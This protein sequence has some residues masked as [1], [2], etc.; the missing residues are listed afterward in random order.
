MA[1]KEI[2]KDKPSVKTFSGNRKVPRPRHPQ[3]LEK[4]FR[5]IEKLPPF[6][7]IDDF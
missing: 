6:E 7:N 2:K 5:A 3:D 1:T 4:F